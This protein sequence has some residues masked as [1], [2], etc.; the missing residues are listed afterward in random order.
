M[1]AD[2]SDVLPLDGMVIALTGAGRGLGL[3]TARTLLARGAKVAA[4]HRTPTP[5]LSELAERSA[6]RLV[7]C[8]GDIG[9]EKA[10]EELVAAAAG[11]G[12]LDALVHNAGVARDQPLVRMPAADWDAVHRVNLRGAF[13]ATK[14]A[15]RPMMRARSGRLVYVS[16]VVART[17]NAGQAAYASSKAGL[18]GL[19][20]TVAQEYARYGIGSVVVSPGLLDVGMTGQMTAQAFEQ[21]TKR[22]LTGV[23]QAR[24]VAAAVAFLVHPDAADI[25]GTVV[26][27]DGGIAY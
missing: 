27:I 26:D 1:P 4:N 8:Q 10:A 6:G 7:T 19:S 15:L 2:P 17:G 13:L 21:K 18:H 20:L 23:V 9:E 11:L 12:G 16:S 24:R 5:E 22:S 25:N 3:E 14:H